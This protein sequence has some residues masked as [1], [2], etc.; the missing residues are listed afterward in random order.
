MLAGQ[1]YLESENNEEA[2]NCFL[3]C[4]RL[5]SRKYENM[6]RLTERFKTTIWCRRARI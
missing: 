6:R 1:D 2:L 5:N 4:D 3:L